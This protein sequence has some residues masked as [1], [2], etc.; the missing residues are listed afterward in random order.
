MKEL[1]EA[2]PPS[3]TASARPDAPELVDPTLPPLSARTFASEQTSSP[4]ALHNPGS[5]PATALSPAASAAPLA[6]AAGQRP[7]L[8][9]PVPTKAATAPFVLPSD[10]SGASPSG[11][12]PSPST[13]LPPPE[14]TPSD[15]ALK[16]YAPLSPSPLGAISLRD[17]STASR[18]ASFTSIP[19]Q[20][21][22]RSSSVPLELQLRD[23]S[24][25]L[26]AVPFFETPLPPAP[27]RKRSKSPFRFLSPKTSPAASQALLPDELALRDAIAALP[28][29]L[30]GDP[31]SGDHRRGMGPRARTGSMGDWE[32]LVFQAHDGF[33]TDAPLSNFRSFG[34]R[35]AAAS[36][37]FF[38]DDV[39]EAGLVG[40][41][42]G[43]LYGPDGTIGKKP[44]AKSMDMLSVGGGAPGFRRAG[45]GLSEVTTNPLFEI[46]D[47]DQQQPASAPAETTAHPQLL[48]SPRS[49]EMML[50]YAA[51]VPTV[52]DPSNP[53][54]SVGDS[55]VVIQHPLPI[56]PRAQEAER[57]SWETVARP[58][59]DLEGLAGSAP[60]S[61]DSHRRTSNA[62]SFDIISTSRL[63]K[64]PPATA[65]ELV[66]PPDTPVAPLRPI[67]RTSLETK[68]IDRPRR[69]NLLLGSIDLGESVT[70]ATDTPP[71][72]S[73]PPSTRPESTVS[74][75]DEIGRTTPGLL[76]DAEL[77]R[78]S[79][80]QV[81][82]SLQ[83]SRLS[84]NAEKGVD[85]ND[86]GEDVEYLAQDER[87]KWLPPPTKN[88]TSRFDPANARP[89]TTSFHGVPEEADDDDDQP[90]DGR[91]RPGKPKSAARLTSLAHFKESGRLA[92]TATSSIFLP[93]VLVMPAPLDPAAYEDG[94]QAANSRGFFETAAKPLPADFKSRPP[95]NHSRSS[96]SFIAS[97]AALAIPDK[98]LTLAQKTFRA[99][100]VVDGKRGNE[101]LGGALEEGD[102]AFEEGDDDSSNHWHVRPEDEYRGPGTLYGRSLMDTLEQRKQEMA[103]KKRYVS[104]R[105]SR[106]FW[107]RPRLT[108]L[109]AFRPSLKGLS[110][111]TTGRRC[112]RARP[113]RPSSRRHRRSAAGPSRST[114]TRRSRPA[115]A[116]PRPSGPRA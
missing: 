19:L 14:R 63:G 15:Q 6:A 49:P 41:G 69:S 7:R 12:S 114:S 74:L 97:A 87:E 13:L 18:S 51:A 101:F 100:L 108:L 76:T 68:T 57:I 110:A 55:P 22:S 30:G 113:R 54:S 1:S 11:Q 17:P 85:A 107:A 91:R 111:A 23:Q 109:C 78:S 102:R 106:S 50:P 25:S 71:S 33:K 58:L 67:S 40:A 115:R 75:L 53:A 47:F 83:L 61:E 79:I 39:S 28:R 59:A 94:Q 42:S 48:P 64:T 80:D 34:S 2:T 45:S 4:V 24:M 103:S 77:G 35:S 56:S 86:D 8:S 44:R 46:P 27:A 9:A 105:R 21:P 20:P 89:R 52:V 116:T 82:R 43:V 62:S 84:R 95:I 98:R 32:D 10:A 36:Q 26:F 81:R 93:P 73:E 90:A 66:E 72:G 31:P 38:E 65:A 70:P 88:R 29:S 96:S 99:S 5:A 16:S 37:V 104:L 60:I 3:V 92:T 112:S